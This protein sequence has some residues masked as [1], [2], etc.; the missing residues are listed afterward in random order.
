MSLTEHYAV[1]DIIV[2]YVTKLPINTLPANALDKLRGVTERQY[3]SLPSGTPL[4]EFTKDAIYSTKFNNRIGHKGKLRNVE[5]VVKR[6]FGQQLKDD[7][8][9]DFYVVALD[10]EK[11]LGKNL[12]D[13][14]HNSLKLKSGLIAKKI[15]A[16]KEGLISELAEIGLKPE[17]KDIYEELYSMVGIQG[18]RLVED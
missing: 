6:H 12:N 16:A 8:E 17:E 9:I 1:S 10:Q 3:V 14:G 13:E 7:I 2:G 11:G 18:V 15:A 5:F 4:F